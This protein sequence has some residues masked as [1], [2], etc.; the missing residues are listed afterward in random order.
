MLLYG[1]QQFVSV[2][3]TNLILFGEG[4]EDNTKEMF[5]KENPLNVQQGWLSVAGWL[6]RCRVPPPL[7]STPPPPPPHT[8]ALS[9]ARGRP[10]G[11][12][13]GGAINQFSFQMSITQLQ[14][15]LHSSLRASRA[16]V[17]TAHIHTPLGC[18]VLMLGQKKKR[19]YRM[20]HPSDV[21]KMHSL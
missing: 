5:G 11:C 14:P 2:N 15:K 8:H 7:Q 3:T 6:A 12:R 19:T 18:D 17:W 21:Q 9:S 1:L 10:A 20:V 13:L 4:S 16:R